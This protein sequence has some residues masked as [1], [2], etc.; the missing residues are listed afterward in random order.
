MDFSKL[1]ETEHCDAGATIDTIYAP[2]GK[3]ILDGVSIK[4]LGSQ[5]T[6]GRASVNM[7]L[8]NKTIRD[9]ESSTIEDRYALTTKKLCALTIGWDGIDMNGVPYPCTAENK[10]ALYENPGYEWL[11]IQVLSFV[12][13]TEN[14]FKMASVN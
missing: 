5:S 6:I 7:S 9:L 2:D 1:N 3:T 13:G 8:K 14:F 4:V 12:E 10:K 11:R